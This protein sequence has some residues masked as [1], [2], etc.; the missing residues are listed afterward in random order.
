MIDRDKYLHHLHEIMAFWIKH[1][2]DTRHGGFHG[3]L[4]RRGTPLPSQPKSLVQHARFLWAFSA[5]YR[6]D[7]QPAYRQMAD[8]AFSFLRERFYDPV[9][10]GWYYLVSAEGLPLN[11]Q[12]H[13]YG[14]SFA[15]YGLSEYFLAFA[16]EEALQ[17]ALQTFDV[18]DQFGHDDQWRGYRESFSE[19]WEPIPQ[20]PD[21]GVSGD[22]KTMNTHIHLLESL[23]NLYRASQEAPVKTRLEELI[24]LCTH[25]ITD[26]RR[27]RV[28]LFFEPDWTPLPS[29]V[30]YGHDIEL[31]WLLREAGDVCGF[32][33]APAIHETSLRLAGTVLRKGLDREDGGV[34]Y[35]GDESGQ[36]TAKQKVWWVQAEALVGF[37]NAYA[38]SGDE[39]FLDA[40]AHVEEWVFTRQVD[41]EY[42]EWH[43]EITPEGECRGE[44]GS[45]WKTPYH[46]GRA[47]MEIVHHT[48]FS[49][50][51]SG[52]LGS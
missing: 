50:L 17:L 21:Y 12:K 52:I 26:A 22:R 27:G 24:D 46:N 8:H 36:V 48:P 49:I 7:P 11:K 37:L 32:G 23:T 5:A 34:F 43:Q 20:H 13:L 19:E 40:F 9:R 47:C 51:D 1:G 44:K 42:G 45:I 10:L 16:H 4:D 25:T 30:S 38:L 39:S 31:S 14:Q 2:P 28:H 6:V 3:A 35:E 41:R 18:I 29:P 33:N 15:I